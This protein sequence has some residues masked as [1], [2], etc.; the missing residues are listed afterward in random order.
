MPATISPDMLEG[1]I[2][3]RELDKAALAVLAAEAE[4]EEHP[5]KTLLA[6]RGASDRRIRY[7]L[8]GEVLVLEDDGTRRSLI[9]MGNAGIAQQPLGLEDPYPFNAISCTEVKLICLSRQQIQERLQAILPRASQVDEVGE[10]DGAVGDRL[11]YRLI[12]DLMQDRL[13]LPSMPDIA[14]RVRQAVNDPA[15][16]APEVARIIQADPVV[17]ARIIQAANSAIFAGKKVADTLNAAVVRLGLKSVREIIVAATMREVFQT[18]HRLLSWRMA[19]LWT[20]STLVAAISAVL[21]RR[22]DGFNPE[23]ALLA[24][25]IHDI[26]VV[27]ILAYAHDYDELARDAALLDNTIAAYRGQIGAMILRRWN[28]PDELITVVLE[29]ENWQRVQ[30][31]K[32]DYADLILASRLQSYSGTEASRNYPSLDDLPAYA[33]LGLGELGISERAPILAE[34]NEEIAAVQRLLVG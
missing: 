27:P 28:F 17:A 34:A 2:P 13:A 33:R 29:A 31:G 15:A 7:V 12:Q 20:Q 3:L 8:S 32:A 1:L 26:G 4:I 24:G 11:F 14:L 10:A 21:S 9:G 6:R 19:E 18:K 30:E 22:L 5:A 25:L 16:G 23:R